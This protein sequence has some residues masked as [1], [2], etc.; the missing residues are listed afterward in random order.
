[1]DYIGFALIALGMVLTPGPN[2]IYL[3]SRTLSQGKLAGLISLIGVGLGFI[4]YMSLTVFGITAMLMAV[5]MAYD[6]LRIAGAIYLLYL[7][8]EALRPGAKSTF[9]VNNLPVDS[10]RKLVIMGYITNLLN[11]KIAVLYL[12]LLPQFIDPSKGNVLSQLFALGFIQILISLTVNTLIILGAS[13]LAKFLSS[14][15]SWIRVQKWLMGG[16]LSYLALR[17]LA[18][19]RK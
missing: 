1:M 9:E 15:P 18:D 7:A 4:T 13:H 14:R 5:P 16:V 6:G 10:P 3:V 17:L 2:M 8:W 12:S 19:S 11:P